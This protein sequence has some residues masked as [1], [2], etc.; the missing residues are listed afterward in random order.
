M[1]TK[2]CVSISG[3]LQRSMTFAW[4]ALILLAGSTIYSQ[5][6]DASSE[7]QGFIASW[8][9]ANKV[10][11]PFDAPPPA[12]SDV[13]LRQIVRISVG[14]S[15]V[16]VWL[17]NESGNAALRVD[18]AT[19]APRNVD[20]SIN[21][22][23]L[24][25]L[26]FNGAASI[27]I[28]AGA[29]VLSDPVALAAGKFTEL[30]ISMHLPTDA[31]SPTSP[32]TYHV[33]ALQTSYIAPGNQVNA[34][35]LPDATTTTAWF[36]LSGVD[37]ERNERMPVIAAFGD[38]I[39]DGD[40]MAAPNEPVD[41]NARYTDFLATL[42]NTNN[43]TGGP[44]R[45]AVINLGISGNQVTQ[46][47]IGENAVGRFDS[48]VLTRSGVTHLVVLEGINDI[49]LPGLLSFIGIPTPAIGAASIISGLQQIAAQA[50]ARNIIVIGGT[51]TP[52]G[53]S[54]LPGYSGPEVDAK[55]QA[56][57]HWI[58]TSR[59]FDAIVDFDRLLRDPSDRTRML[60]ALTADGLHPNTEG[61]QLMAEELARV[62]KRGLLH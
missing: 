23:R 60:A 2:N 46:T 16:R 11:S 14:G 61:Y 4:S 10:P 62:L 30:A 17:T 41:Q 7:D 27:V 54:L 49:G 55:R 20:S 44:T 52:S 56:V 15:R 25:Q 53:G 8:T 32:V 36:Y 33:R 48:D 59:V 5:H 13:T 18:A 51:L 34:A 21:T 9:A 47:F 31:V 57:N 26:T 22:A 12:F 6:V 19:I 37:V 28:P 42:L 45:A 24:R 58:R 50:R 3:R 1:R 38:S 39:T 43:G 29:R 40:Q 35:D